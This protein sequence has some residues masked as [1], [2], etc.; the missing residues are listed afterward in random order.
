MD[1]P[2]GTGGGGALSR[3]TRV[4]A[5][6]VAAGVVA[7]VVVG[8]VVAT[9]NSGPAPVAAVAGGGSDRVSFTGTDPI[10]GQPVELAAYRGKPVVINIWASWCPGCNVE[11]DDLRRFAQAHPEAQVVGVNIQDTEGGARDFYRRW[12]WDWP[13]VSD[14]SGELAASLGLQG[15]P[16]TLFLDEDHQVVAR[17]VG[18]GDLERFEEGLRQAT[19]G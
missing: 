11:A 9:R 5:G 17:I 3:R 15:L 18:E 6:V 7:L 8:V 4:F 13:S 14:P 16:T 12:D 19:A 1:S 2:R 10:T